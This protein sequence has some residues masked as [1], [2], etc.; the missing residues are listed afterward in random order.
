MAKLPGHDC[1]TESIL[2]T[3][4]I[5]IPLHTFGCLLGPTLG[6]KLIVRAEQEGFLSVPC[7]HRAVAAGDGWSFDPL[8]QSRLLCVLLISW[9]EV[10]NGVLNHVPGVYGL[11]QAA[12]DAFHGS[13]A[14]WER[15]KAKQ[16]LRTEAQK[17]NIYLV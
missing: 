15:Q 13:R 9:R 17:Q 16:I 1:N 4:D 5:H 10:V 7:A 2:E 8:F 12:R 11:L 14:T 3:K 6:L